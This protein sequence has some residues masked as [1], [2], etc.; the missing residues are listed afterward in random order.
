MIFLAVSIG[1]ALL[2]VAFVPIVRRVSMAFGFLDDPSREPER[3]IHTRPTPLLGGVSVWVMVT[4]G[5]L[6]LLRFGASLPTNFLTVPALVGL[7][8]GSTIIMIGGALDDRYHLRARASIF[9]PLAA[10]LIMVAVGVG[11]HF[12]TNPFGGVLRIDHWKILLF[13]G[14]SINVGVSLFTIIW[15]MGMMYTTKLLDGLDGLVSGLTAIAAGI[16]T[17]LCLMPPVLQF[18][19]ALLSALVAGAFAGFLVY[20]WNPASIFLGEGGSVLAGFYLGVLGIV[21]GGKIATTL[22]VIGIPALD[23]LWVIVRRVFWEG[24]G[25]ASAD[26]KHLHFRLLDRGLSVRQTVLFYYSI[27]AVFGVIALTQRTTGKLV[28]LVLLGLLMLI[29]AFMVVRTSRH[30]EH[31]S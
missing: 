4:L 28:A 24:H 27:A 17:V 11:V 25:F 1:A 26:R 21:S 8:G 23:V 29:V 6:L 30:S 15:L 3:L 20:N 16:I 13:H 9:F 12:V 5:I 31:H 22:L 18:D 7:I 14:A 2:T 10:A 19:T